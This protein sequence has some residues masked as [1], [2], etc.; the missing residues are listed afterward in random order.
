[1]QATFYNV[2]EG[3]GSVTVCAEISDI[4]TGGLECDVVISLVASPGLKSGECTVLVVT[5]SCLSFPLHLSLSQYRGL[6][7]GSS[8]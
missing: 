8:H 3:D 2:D 7:L 1:M 5:S 6:R 4:P